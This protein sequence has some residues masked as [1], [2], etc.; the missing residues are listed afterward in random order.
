MAP[1]L[2]QYLPAGHKRL[3]VVDPGD[4]YLVIVHTLGGLPGSSQ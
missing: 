2:V 3:H 1:L 4:E